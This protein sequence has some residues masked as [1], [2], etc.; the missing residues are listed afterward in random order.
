L[1][2]WC[3]LQELFSCTYAFCSVRFSVSRFILK[4]LIHLDLSFVQG[5]RYGSIFILLH[6]DTQLVQHYCWIWLSFSFFKF[7]LDIFFVYISNVIYFPCFPSENPLSPPPTHQTSTPDSLSWNSS[8]LG[9]QA[10]T[11]T[12]TSPSINV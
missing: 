8:T 3:F 5:D 9:H 11:E 2:H 10:F 6:I 12:R 1:S 4:F 7:L